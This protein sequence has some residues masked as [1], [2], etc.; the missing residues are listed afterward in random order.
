LLERAISQTKGCYVGQEV[1]IRVLH[2][3]GG[4]VAKRLMKIS[5]E[6]GAPVPERGTSI[7]A[8]GTSIGAITSSAFSARDNR[9]V[10]L[11][12]V[13]REF[14]E[15]GTPIEVGSTPAVLAAPAS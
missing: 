1:I 4:R 12:Y 11:G 9:A 5:L 15:A 13:K 8:G 3:G 6:P 2:R 14:A 10:A 7:N